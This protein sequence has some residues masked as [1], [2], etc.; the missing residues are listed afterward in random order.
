MGSRLG[1]IAG[2]GELSR[3]VL[4]EAKKSG[5]FCAVAGLRGAA[6]LL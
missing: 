5:L 1:L 4:A 2:A 6:P 3:A